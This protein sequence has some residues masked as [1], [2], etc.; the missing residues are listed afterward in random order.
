MAEEREQR[1][2][3]FSPPIGPGIPQVSIAEKVKADFGYEIPTETVP[4]PSNGLTYP[5]GSPLHGCETVDIR[6]MTTRE[7]DILTNQALLKKGTVITELIRSCLVNRAIEPLDMLTGDRTALTVAIRITGYGAEYEAEVTCRECSAKWMQT[8]DL[9]ALPIQRLEMAPLEP[10]TNAF[11][12]TL[13]YTRKN[14]RFRFLTG[15]DEEEITALAAKQKKLG[16][17]SEASVTS[18]LLHSIVSIDGI[19]DRAKIG[20]FVRNMPAR[21]SRAL[22]EHVRDHEPGIAMRQEVTCQSC[23]HTEEVTIPFGTSFLWPTAGK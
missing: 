16:L 19:D 20:A 22:R 2:Q 13:P 4:L 8:F 18:N 6:A 14:V 17:P 12:F 21:D 7:E 1:N 23:D 15:R 3:V 5:T 9:A 10:G 11:E